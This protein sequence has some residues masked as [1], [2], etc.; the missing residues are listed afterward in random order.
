MHGVVSL[1]DAMSYDKW[2]YI[3]PRHVMT[4]C[5]T[6]VKVY[7]HVVSFYKINK[8]VMGFTNDVCGAI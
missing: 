5:F 6:E 2:H 7:I 4:N 3:A 8:R 1:P